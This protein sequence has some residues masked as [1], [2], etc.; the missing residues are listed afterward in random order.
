MT[1]EGRTFTP[2]EGGV[3]N[4][5]Y[6]DGRFLRADDLNRER[7]SQR[8]YVE[9][10]NRVTASGTAWG[11]GVTGLGGGK[12]HLAAGLARTP[13][14]QI[15]Y[16]PHDVSAEVPDLLGT[17]TTAPAPADPEAAFAECAAETSVT[18][19]AGD[20]VAGTA[21]YEVCLR[22]AATLTGTGEV[23]GRLCD[24]CGST[25][26]SPYRADGVT[27]LLRPLSADVQPWTVAGVTRPATHL[28]SQVASARFAAERAAAGRVSAPL[29]GST[30]WGAGAA[31]QAGDDTVA[32]GVLGWNGTAITLLD[33]WTAC[34]EAVQ[35]PS[36][37]YWAGQLEQRPAA[38][39][40]AQVLQFQDQLSAAPAAPGGS[41]QQLLDRGFVELPAAGYLPVPPAAQDLR[42]R[43]AAQF[44]PGVRLWLCAVRRD[45]IPHEFERAQHMERISLLRGLR[46]ETARE[47]VDVLVPD[48]TVTATEPGLGFAV[49]FA[50]GNDTRAALD[51]SEPNPPG[52]LRG[53]GVG[54]AE[55]GRG[56]EVRGALS[57]SAPP[58]IEA[59]ARFL[60]GDVPGLDGLDTFLATI[61]NAP[62]AAAP[63]P[64]Q[65]RRLVDLAQITE[66]RARSRRRPALGALA[67]GNDRVTAV[68]AHL[69]VDDDPFRFTSRQDSTGF[70]LEI[71]VYRPSTTPVSFNLR[72]S[73]TLAWDS[74]AGGE[75]V[76]SASGYFAL[77]TGGPGGTGT[78]GTFE[79]RKLRLSRTTQDGVTLTARD[80]SGLVAGLHFRG[81]PVRAEAS[82]GTSRAVA[83]TPAAALTALQEPAVAEPG[84]AYHQS[85]A[86]A[87]SLLGGVHTDPEWA[88]DEYR[89]LFPAGDRPA[90][91][92]Q[93][94]QD[95]VLFRRRRRESCEGD[96]VTPIA[97]DTVTVQVLTMPGSGDAREAARILLTGSPDEWPDG[98]QASEVVFEGGTT[99]LLTPGPSWQQ[100]YRSA[101]GANAIALA[102]YAAAPGALGPLVGAG[103]LRALL[104]ALPPGVVPDPAL[105]AV[106]VIPPSGLRPGPGI[107]GSA[108]LIT[109][110]PTPPPVRALAVKAVFVSEANQDEI[111]AVRRP[112][113]AVD[114]GAEAFAALGE[115]GPDSLRIAG[116]LAQ[117][118][119]FRA[120]QAS[121]LEAVRV[122]TVIWT[123]PLLSDGE[124]EEMLD[125]AGQVQLALAG[126]DEVRS[127]TKHDPI[128]VSYT[129][130]ED[131][132][133]AFLFLIVSDAAV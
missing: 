18:R 127:L 73:G 28:R 23:F 41:V 35:T 84:N 121:A 68:W 111:D 87:L 48:G 34:R 80:E 106:P 55:T 125:L 12:L 75:S 13:R 130:A 92:V 110:A 133:V 5:N 9:L 79:L 74:A 24:G 94:T 11:F 85:A 102:G 69:R 39:F 37:G 67:A 70:L 31:Q 81:E 71:D 103:R 14:G 116:V 86:A 96:P 90:A 10:S 33:R 57:S 118:D 30:L 124:R 51:E 40:L 43:L 91:T 120:N 61:R 36:A 76:V 42:D 1:V 105:P 65:L 129:R 26:D 21:L 82:I 60:R 17:A 58:N 126:R 25:T 56:F 27:L 98:W 15:L 95:W 63:S 112:D 59:L 107:S 22:P 54:R 78:G 77:S 100:R 115:G 29:L 50:F 66:V 113:P 99:T 3:V 64:A 46:D 83:H 122:E 131:D 8:A 89:R 7:D 114:T 32:V 49:D 93:A 88:P 123:H 19:P 16:L 38:V 72:I 128:Q 45:Q 109:Y 97:V 101:G 52:T 44:G 108:F 117:L 4:L 2:D 47:E 62:P 20:T 104:S 119:T 53:Q 132:P 6:Y